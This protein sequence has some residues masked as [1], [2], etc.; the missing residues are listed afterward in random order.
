MHFNVQCCPLMSSIECKRPQNMQKVIVQWDIS[1]ST[2]YPNYKKK[3]LELFFKNKRKKRQG[4][5]LIH[6]LS[7]LRMKQR[8]WVIRNLKAYGK[9]ISLAYI[10]TKTKGFKENVYGV[11]QFITVFL[12]KRISRTGQTPMISEPQHLRRFGSC[13]P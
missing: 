6:C 9:S 7:V 2:P 1:P 4:K 10:G 8:S 13:M 12:L 5:T 11:C 3:L